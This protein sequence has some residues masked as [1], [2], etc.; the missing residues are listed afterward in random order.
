MK[1]EMYYTSY[2][3]AQILLSSN[4]ILLSRYSCSKPKQIRWGQTRDNG[5][6]EASFAL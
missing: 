6:S 5:A 1:H 4:V 3:I 2:F